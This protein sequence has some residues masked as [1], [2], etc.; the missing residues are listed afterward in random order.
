KFLYKQEPK[1]ALPV[2]QKV[3]VCLIFLCWPPLAQ[4]WLPIRSW[5]K[6]PTFHDAMTA[7]ISNITEF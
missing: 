6:C 2:P 1:L 5:R 7:H 3:E 4:E